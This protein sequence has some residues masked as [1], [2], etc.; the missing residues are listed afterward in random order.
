[1]LIILT[2][3]PAG[4]I[5]WGGSATSITGSTARTASPA[6]GPRSCSRSWTRPRSTASWR[7]RR[8]FMTRGAAA[9]DG[10]HN[11]RP[12]RQTAQR[13]TSPRM[14]IA[15]RFQRRRESKAQ[16]MLAKPGE[17]GAKPGEAE[18]SKSAPGIETLQ[19][20]AQESKLFC[21]S[22]GGPRPPAGPR[23]RLTR[24]KPGPRSAAR[25]EA[26]APSEGTLPALAGPVRQRVRLAEP[27][28]G[29]WRPAFQKTQRMRGLAHNE[30]KQAPKNPFTFLPF[31]SLSFRIWPLSMRYASTGPEIFLAPP[32]HNN[33]RYWLYMNACGGEGRRRRAG[34]HE[35]AG[36]SM[37]TP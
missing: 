1:M 6:S 26:P 12:R 35:R 9:A 8:R 17:T 29:R 31:P 21:N 30:A 24:A 10:P 27:R 18:Q 2:G 15:S 28:P 19:T 37:F 32:S 25:L 14:L 3:R 20:L 11:P 4:S 23:A 33:V 34:A 7:S 5:G 22:R 16:G 36:R 13:R